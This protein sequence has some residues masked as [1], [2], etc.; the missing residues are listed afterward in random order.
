MEVKMNI[1]Y[2]LAGAMFGFLIC[3][4]VLAVHY[5]ATGALQ[6]VL[7]PFVWVFCL[8]WNP[9]RWLFKPISN[10]R[11]ERV[12]RAYKVKYKAA[13]PLRFCYDPAPPIWRIYNKFYIVRLKG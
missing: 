1:A 3:W 13:G 9:I 2:F 7:T 11:W 12:Q 8:V 4:L 10:E 6:V 5:D